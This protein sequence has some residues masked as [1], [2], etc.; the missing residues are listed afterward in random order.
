MTDI[1]G[2]QKAIKR[3]AELAAQCAETAAEQYA[4]LARPYRG[5][6]I[7]AGIFIMIVLL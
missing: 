4:R 1:W 7:L 3:T 6:G 5:C 2:Q